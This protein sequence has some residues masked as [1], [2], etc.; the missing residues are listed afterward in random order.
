[1]PK[2][3]LKFRGENSARFIKVMKKVI[4]K[5]AQYKDCIAKETAETALNEYQSTGEIIIINGL[6]DALYE[7]IMNYGGLFDGHF[8]QRILKGD[9]TKTSDQVMLNFQDEYRMQREYQ[10]KVTGIK[11]LVRNLRI[12]SNRDYVSD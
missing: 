5:A 6:N 8:A 12:L 1:M 11:R 2:P 9:F 4:R 10:Q 7:L 3:R